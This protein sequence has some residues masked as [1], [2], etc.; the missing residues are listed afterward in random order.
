V[1]LALLTG[2]YI[3]HRDWAYSRE[4]H[5][6]VLANLSRL[7]DQYLPDTPV[8]WVLGNHEGV[9]VG[10]AILKQIF[11]FILLRAPR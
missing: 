11:I 7:V 3:D 5:T 8:Y 1:D 10:R 6:Q 9:P 4:G 2:D